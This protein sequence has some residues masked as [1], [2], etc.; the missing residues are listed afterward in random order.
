[1]EK[2]QRTTN[3]ATTPTPQPGE[4]GGGV[5]FALTAAASALGGGTHSNPLG[6]LAVAVLRAVVPADAAAASR[7][8]PMAPR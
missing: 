1:M 2:S 7:I 8:R 6:V 3:P 5:Q 4:G